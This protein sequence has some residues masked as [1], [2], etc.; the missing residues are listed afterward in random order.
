MSPRR[1]VNPAARRRAAGALTVAFL[2]LAAMIVGAVLIGSTGHVRV[3]RL[4]GLHKGAVKAKARRLSLQPHF[5]WRYDRAAKGT[6]IAQ[7][8]RPGRRVSD[9]S[10]IAVVLSAG[11]PPVKIPQLAGDSSFQAQSELAHIGLQART[12]QIIAPGV[13]AGAVT[14]QSPAPGAKIPRGSTV[15][16]NVAEVPHW[17]SLTSFSGG[18]SS[19][20]L[21]FHVRG[22]Q[23][24]VV[25]SMGYVGTCTFVIFCSGPSAKV[26]G[27]GGATTGFD[28]NQGHHQTRV[29]HPGAGSYQ[30]TVS[31][32]D[33]TTR[34]SMWVEDYY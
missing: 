13:P 27:S 8:P 2:L 3:P 25:Y 34:W 30:L 33:D 1:N 5:R 31:P 26:A 23:W 18:D 29:F 17:Q 9:G 4:A 22:T 28:L 16:L 6:V 7:R 14:S 19:R 12:T 15:R 20:T 21:R 10:S 24:R 32:G 11:P